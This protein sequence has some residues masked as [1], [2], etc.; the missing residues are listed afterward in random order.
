MGEA[1]AARGPV[2]QAAA[3]AAASDRLLAPLSPAERLSYYEHAAMAAAYETDFPV[4]AAMR[5][6]LGAVSG[7]GLDRLAALGTPEA[8]ALVALQSADHARARHLFDAAPRAMRVRAL[9]LARARLLSDPG[10]AGSQARLSRG[11]DVLAASLS[12]RAASRCARSPSPA[13]AP[14][15]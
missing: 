6:A 7:Y 15:R 1:S 11:L 10:F 9:A 5:P 4:P 14:P 12:R 13:C 3:F 8:L 2:A